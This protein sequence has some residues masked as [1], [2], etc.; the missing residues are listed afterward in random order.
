MGDDALS[1]LTGHG[2]T[3]GMGGDEGVKTSQGMGEADRCERE[4][5]KIMDGAG[6]LAHG[7]SSHG[8]GK[9]VLERG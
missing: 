3:E 5:G 7:R 4:Q 8:V 6:W 1:A 9:L 2:D